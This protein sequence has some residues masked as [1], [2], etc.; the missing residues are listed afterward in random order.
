VVSAGSIR[1]QAPRFLQRKVGGRPAANEAS[2]TDGELISEI[3][4]A[5]GG[6]LSVWAVLYEDVYET[7]LGDGYYAYLADAFFT[8]EESERFAAHSS[9]YRFHVRPVRLTFDGALRMEA[10]LNRSERVGIDELTAALTR[11]TA[12]RIPKSQY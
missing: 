4:A 7:T 9:A 5:P 10:D 12:P 11:D 2:M 1:F 8:R 3:R 6:E